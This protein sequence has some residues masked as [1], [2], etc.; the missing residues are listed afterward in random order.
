MTEMEYRQLG[1][2]GLTVSV[3]GLGCNNFGGRI[4]AEQADAVVAAAVDA[5]ITLFDTADVYGERGGS[6]RILGKALGKRRD[7]VVIATKFG[8]DMKGVNGPDWGVRGSRRYIRKAVESSLARLGTDWIDLY[9][10]HMPDLMTPIE[11]TLAALSE[12]VAEGK[13][14]YLGS[15]QFA[16]WQVVDADWAARTAGLE[17]F[18]SAQ[19]KYS[20]LDRA[21][22]DELVPA[23]EH[24]GIGILPYF[25][26]ES[27]LLTG[28]Y[29]RGEDAP[30]GSRLAKQ[31]ERLAR[32]DFDK[33]EA[34]ETF[35]AERDLT[36]LDVAIGGLAAQPAVGSVIAGATTPEQIAQNVAA[37]SWD[38]TAEDLATLDD[39][40]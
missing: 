9:Q 23:C 11:E 16:G 32:A 30:D 28:K 20:L 5:G 14:R 22:E 3:V 38:P 25:P 6:E 24:L 18:V 29:R 35:A 4:G 15:S 19:N 13:V 39:L 21:I 34:L 26:L 40:T 17:H 36:L 10:L 8:G 2:S 1:D 7:E 37:G 27:G 33:L 31:P 12:L